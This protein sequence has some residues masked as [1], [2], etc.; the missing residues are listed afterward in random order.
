MYN[1][2]SASVLFVLAEMIGTLNKNLQSSLRQR[3][4]FIARVLRKE[5]V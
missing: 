4:S 2:L 3:F 1:Y 5:E